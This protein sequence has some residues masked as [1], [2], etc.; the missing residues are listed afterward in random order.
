M[1]DSIKEP[2]PFDVFLPSLNH[3][4]DKAG[5]SYLLICGSE[6]GPKSTYGRGFLKN[7]E[8]TILNSNPPII[9][10]TPSPPTLDSMDRDI[11]SDCLTAPICQVTELPLTGEPASS[12]P[13]PQ[14]YTRSEPVLFGVREQRQSR[15][16]DQRKNLQAG[17]NSATQENSKSQSNDRA[18]IKGSLLEFSST[19]YVGM[20]SVF[21][22]YDGSFKTY[23]YNGR[24][25][26]F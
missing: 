11:V 17:S 12:S 1:D 21:Y 3:A 22:F 15:A 10:E 6:D 23:Q 20:R 25:P 14:I 2:N 8:L 24:F 16:Q 26:I 7:R 18:Q 13:N 19:S 9:Y 4:A 5:L